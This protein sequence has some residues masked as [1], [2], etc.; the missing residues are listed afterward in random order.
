MHANSSVFS[1]LRHDSPSAP[2]Q[3]VDSLYEIENLAS[4]VAKFDQQ[5]AVADLFAPFTSGTSSSFKNLVNSGYVRFSGA[6]GYIVC[7]LF[8]TLLHKA[9]DLMIIV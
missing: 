6:R 2:L 9:N 3:M 4:R 5:C 7:V 1:L 8:Q